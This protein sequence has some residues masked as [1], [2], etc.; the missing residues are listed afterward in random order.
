MPP[1]PTGPA[2]ATPL[3]AC[4]YSLAATLAARAPSPIPPS[5]TG[6]GE[7][8]CP[9]PACPAMP[10]VTPAP[11]GAPLMKIE[12][13]Y[14]LAATLATLAPSPIPPSPTGPPDALCPL[15]ACPAMP[16]VTP[17]PLGGPLLKIEELS[18]EMKT[19]DFEGA[20][21]AAAAAAAAAAAVPEAAA[22]AAAPD[23]P[24]PAPSLPVPPNP[25]NPPEKR[26]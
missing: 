13:L 23:N 1:S 6:P 14:S 12:E 17:A 20:T 8:L 25:K 19:G 21:P 10:V 15:P 18:A 24:A 22:E 2:D 16:V 9:L 3:P 5:P 11:L 7:A 4:A 26:A